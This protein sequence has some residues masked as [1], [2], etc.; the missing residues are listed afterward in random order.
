MLTLLKIIFVVAV[1][2]SAPFIF[3]KFGRFVV[4]AFMKGED[5]AAWKKWRMMLRISLT[6]IAGVY[7]IGAISIA[8]QIFNSYEASDEQAGGTQELHASSNHETGHSLP[9]GR[10]LVSVQPPPE[11]TRREENAEPT[12]APAQVKQP[13]PE[14]APTPPPPPPPTRAG[15]I[16]L[17][18]NRRFGVN[19]DALPEGL[20]ITRIGPGPMESAGLRIGDLL[21][22]LEGEPIQGESKLLEIRN[23]IFDGRIAGAEITVRRGGK[24]FSYRLQK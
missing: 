6:L 24:E 18:K 12:P 13:R 3:Y 17:G 20:L 10:P 11:S 9:F 5:E 22:T 7:V 8:P 15:S 1:A 19:W 16:L 2:V 4:L 23:R 21:T 14:A